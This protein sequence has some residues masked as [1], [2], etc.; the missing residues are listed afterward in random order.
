MKRITMVVAMK[1]EAAPLIE[2][3]GLTETNDT[4]P[5]LPCKTF[6]GEYK[7]L[8]IN[9]IT[10]GSD[11]VH[12]VENVGTQPATLAAYEALRLLSPELVINAG[13]C[14]GFPTRAVKLV[15]FILASAFVSLT[16]VSPWATIT[17]P[18]ETVIFSAKWQWTWPENW[19]CPP[20]LSAP[21]TL[22][23]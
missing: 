15:T 23:I 6:A 8:S 21:A 22:S 18:M 11:S 3:L 19:I 2:K 17:K 4:N 12:G 1:Q 10:N 13:T 5:L 7:N 20:L 9:L 14:G 16:V